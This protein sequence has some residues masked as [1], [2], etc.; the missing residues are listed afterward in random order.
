M[1]NSAIIMTNEKRCS[2]KEKKMP[3]HSACKEMPRSL[4]RVSK[5]LALTTLMVIIEEMRV[6]GKSGCSASRGAGVGN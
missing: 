1:K 6:W 2:Q 4:G 3:I 5:L